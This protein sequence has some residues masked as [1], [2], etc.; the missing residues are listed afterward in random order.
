MIVN[1]EEEAKAREKYDKILTIVSSFNIS[2][3]EAG[4]DPF[5]F[6]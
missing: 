1:E 3:R 6:W 5:K 4:S 2:L